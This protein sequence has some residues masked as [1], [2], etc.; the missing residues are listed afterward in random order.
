MKAL[1]ISPFLNESFIVNNWEI[2][3]TLTQLRWSTIWL[4]YAKFSCYF[5]NRAERFHY[6]KMAFAEISLVLTKFHFLW[7]IYVCDFVLNKC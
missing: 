5:Y 3:T 2:K 1:L 4:G 6:Q 7:R